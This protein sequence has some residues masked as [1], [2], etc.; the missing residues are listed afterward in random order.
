MDGV[1][2][3]GALSFDA[4]VSGL[5]RAEA[6][7]V[8]YQLL[9]APLMTCTVW[10]DEP[11]RTRYLIFTSCLQAHVVVVMCRGASFGAACLIA[12]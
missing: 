5:T 9:G 1:E 4:C 12:V 3:E 2:G 6:A 10:Q 7:K 8:F 11:G